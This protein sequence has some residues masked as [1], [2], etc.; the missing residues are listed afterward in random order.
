MRR[1]LY[2]L[3]LTLVV[4]AGLMPTDASAAGEQL[5]DFTLRDIDNKEVSVKD[6]RGKVV[7][8]NFWATW[9]QPCMVEMTHLQKMHA[10]L[11]AKGFTVLSISADDAR[12]AS[13]VKPVIKRNGYTFPVLLD[14]ETK[15]VSQLN[16]SKTLPYT[17]IVDKE[18]RIVATHMGYNPGDE[19]GMRKEVEAL[20]SGPDL[21]GGE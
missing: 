15:V 8:L 5:P 12:S 21:P 18:G 13:M 10:E 11:G 20:L 6:F 3:L 1:A 4:A 7:L 16:P 2:A 9:C 14:K 19:V 17:V